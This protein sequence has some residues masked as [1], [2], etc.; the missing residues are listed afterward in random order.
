MIKC[1]NCKSTHSVEN[2]LNSSAEFKP[3]TNSFVFS[4]PKCNERIDSKIK[5]NLVILGYIYGAG[6][7]HFSGMIEYKTPGVTYNVKNTTLSVDYFGGSWN[8]K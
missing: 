5:Q 6:E 8:I 3:V 4:C 7:L 2:F 1:P